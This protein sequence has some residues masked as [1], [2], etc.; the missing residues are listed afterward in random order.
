MSLSEKTLLDWAKEFCGEP[1][2]HVSRGELIVER[3]RELG[4]RPE[5]KVLDIGCG[6]LSQG[7]PLIRY[8]NPGNY[9]GIDPAGWLILAAMYAEP[10]LKDRNPQFLYRSDF[11]ASGYG[12]YDFVVSHSVMSHTAH[13]QME[14]M[15]AKI[16]ESSH[17]GT[18][19]LSSLR[20][21]QYDMFAPE[22]RYPDISYF[23]LRTVQTLGFYFGWFVVLDDIMK[24]RLVENNPVDS[25]EWVTLTA[26]PTSSEMNERRIQLETDQA[27]EVEHQRVEKELRE[28]FGRE[29]MDRLSEEVGDA[30][31]HTG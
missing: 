5:H 30:V 20:I 27:N 12:T 16:R 8:L 17:E 25:L 21:D 18:L 3:M 7:S 10:Q 1:S 11:D 14:S 22:W 28:T 6:A 26:I 31:P 15:L 24:N 4:L 2:S 19:W 23:R 13:W 9:V 29:R